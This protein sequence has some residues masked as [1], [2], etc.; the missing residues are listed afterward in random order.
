M[1]SK[2]IWQFDINNREF[3][4]IINEEKEKGMNSFDFVNI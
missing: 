2:G 4:N 3:D 1:N